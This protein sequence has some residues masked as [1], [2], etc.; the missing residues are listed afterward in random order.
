MNKKRWDAPQTVAQEYR[1]GAQYKASLGERGLFR[2]NEMNERFFIGDQ[3]NGVTT[4]SNRP[5][6]RNNII[7]RIGE[8]KLSTINNPVTINFSAD[9]VPE[10]WEMKERVRNLERG[11]L[12][13]FGTP[14]TEDKPMRIT[15]VGIYLG[16]NRIIHSSHRVRINSL[17][18]GETDYYENSHRLTGA[19]RL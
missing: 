13:F 14:A 18:P 11:D 3:W 12:V 6:V 15:H 9:G 7:K 2:Q 5:L 10:T 1:A 4:D 19:T 8:L 16:N 17:I